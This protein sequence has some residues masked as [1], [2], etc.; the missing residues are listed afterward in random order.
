MAVYSFITQHDIDALQ[1]TY[2]FAH[3]NA[4]T[5]IAEGVENSNYMLDIVQ[6]GKEMRAILTIF[7]ARVAAD[8]VPFF[9]HL[10]QHLSQKG[11]CCP[12]PFMTIQGDIYCMIQQKCAAVVSFLEGAS[13]YHPEVRH[14]AQAAEGLARLHLAGM[15]FA[16]QRDNA[17]NMAGWKTL[18]HKIAHRA[19]SVEH[20]A[21]LALI[22]D[23]LA[24]QAQHPMAHLPQGIIHA[25][26]F[27]NNVFFDT[28]DR[29]CGIID[30][31]FACNDSL[32]YDLAIVANAWCCDAS[33][34]LQT[35]AFDALIQHYAAIR[36]LTH[37]EM[38][39]M[40]HLLR[41]ASLRFLLTRLHD[42]LYPQP[43]ALVTPHN[44]KEYV[45]KLLW[46]RSH[47][48]SISISAAI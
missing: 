19:H 1:R 17:M 26:L 37:E 10:K 12:Y 32:A 16:M 8:D 36:P 48:S 11:L 9:L 15:D 28:H 35:D 40:P 4:A 31:Y 47:A 3:I 6:N 29:L 20:R 46:H 7:E 13:V 38:H 18:H 44:P 30:F 39:A 45:E 23:E 21:W 24:H 34:A 41:A 43:D 22:E 27:P 25:D 2:G 33:G 14:I 42:V 5:P